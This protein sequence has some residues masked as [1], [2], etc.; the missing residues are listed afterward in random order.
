[1]W[2]WSGDAASARSRWKW[3]RRLPC[4][5]IESKG[6]AQSC[7]HLFDVDVHPPPKLPPFFPPPPPTT[8]P[9]PPPHPHPPPCPALPRSAP[10]RST[11]DFQEDDGHVTDTAQVFS[12][13]TRVM[14]NRRNKFDPLWNSLVVAGCDKGKPFLGQVTPLAGTAASQ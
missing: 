5:F 14:Y 12:Y 6:A 8:P 1:M 7:R 4:W 3:Q 2:R 11:G 10:P 13:L 9:T